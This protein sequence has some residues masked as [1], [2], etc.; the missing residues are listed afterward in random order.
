MLGQTQGDESF[1]YSLTYGTYK[2]L[3]E[4]RIVVREQEGPTCLG[5]V[6]WR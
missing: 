5:G 3:V 2:I 1:V 4:N 6:S